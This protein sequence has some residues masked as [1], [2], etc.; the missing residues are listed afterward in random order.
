[1]AAVSR[2]SSVLSPGRRAA[3]GTPRAAET[4]KTSLALLVGCVSALRPP[5]SRSPLVR[6]SASPRRRDARSTAL[7]GLSRPIPHIPTVPTEVGP[8]C[9]RDAPSWPT[10]SR[11]VGSCPRWITAAVPVLA[12]STAPRPARRGPSVRGL[13]CPSAALWGRSGT[14]PGGSAHHGTAAAAADTRRRGHVTRPGVALAH[15]SGHRAREQHGSGGVVAVSPCGG[16][17]PSRPTGPL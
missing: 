8:R 3:V 6:S 5:L 14:I 12:T 2:R 4:G 11:W 17:T 10:A 1:M 7:R 9:R 15:R 16:A 13:A